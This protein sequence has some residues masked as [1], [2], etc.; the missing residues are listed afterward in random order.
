MVLG[1]RFRNWLPKKKR[2]AYPYS[3][4]AKTELN[5]QKTPIDD[6]DSVSEI[7]SDKEEKEEKE[8]EDESDTFNKL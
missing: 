1:P 3:D 5:I 4:E 8:D 2:F 6:W 7:S